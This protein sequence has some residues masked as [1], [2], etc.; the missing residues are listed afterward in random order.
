MHRRS[1][2]RGVPRGLWAVS[3]A[4]AIA[5]AVLFVTLTDQGR[6]TRAAAALLPD[7][8]AA[9]AWAGLGID[10]VSVSGHRFTPDGD[11]L[12]ALDMRNVRT[13]AALDGPAV[14]A[15]IERLPWIATAELMRI[16]PGRLDVRV[17]ERKAYGL[18]QTGAR[19][20]LFDATG[21]VLGD[22]VAGSVTGLARF[23][24]EGAPAHG[25]A[26]MATVARHP[27]IATRL[28]LAE[29]V[30]ERRWTLHLDNGTSLLLP[31]DGEAAAL[32]RV[33]SR[34]ALARLVTAPGRVVDL[35]A[36]GRLAVR[37]APRSAERLLPH[38]TTAGG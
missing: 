19:E 23:R 32:Q 7:A 30:D 18:W 27:T 16:Y 37:A 15:R 21:R 26:L 14:R 5:G 6:D 24:G 2:P 33:L 1:R 29:R 34:P 38:A 3:V 13:W 35:R 31:A 25:P 20:R 12:D 10:Q 9:L 22:V 17:T 11:I 28:R 8:D 4:G 36:P